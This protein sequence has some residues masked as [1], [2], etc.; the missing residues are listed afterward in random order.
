[1]VF[2]FRRLYQKGT[3]LLLA[4]SV[5]PLLAQ[6]RQAPVRSFPSLDPEGQALAFN[7]LAQ[8][9]NYTWK[10][11]ADIALWSSQAGERLGMGPDGPSAREL[12]LQAAQGLQAGFPENPKEGGARLLAYIHGQYL[13][14]YAPHQTL[15]D[16]LLVTGR[17]NCVSSAVFYAILAASAGL[18][19]QGVITRDH[20]FV[21]LH[22]GGEAVDVE[23]TNAYGYD[24]GNRR[25]FQNAFGKT[26]G[27]TYVPAR[28][29]RDRAAISALELVSLILSNRIA[30]A[31]SQRRYAGALTLAVNRDALLAGRREAVSSP[32]FRDPRA[33]LLDR[34]F[35]YTASLIQAGAEQDALAWMD[36]AQARY[37][38]DPRW[39]EAAHSAVNNLLVKLLRSQRYGEARTVLA[40][41]ARR[42]TEQA[43]RELEIQTVDAEFLFRAGKI[44]S[45]QGA[46]QLLGDLETALASGQLPKNRGEALRTFILLKEG[47]RAAESGGFAGGIR[48]L[49]GAIARYGANIRME[50][51]LRVYQANRIAELHNRFAGLFNQRDYAGAR[52]LILAALEEFPE[53]RRLQSDLQTLERTLGG[54]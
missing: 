1:M 49:E 44:T 51:A 33:D 16:T 27:F 36:I 54:R 39:E 17:Y 35:N 12:L 42:L 22:A 48:Y 10:D 21:S 31:E 23:T 5:S 50:E 43:R 20:A 4:V 53:N 25:E 41:N 46:E 47:E 40:Q 8:S 13:K 15:L 29:Y 32:F 6:S 14:S 28:N 30:E 38:E 19:V 34:I 11:L 7:R 3:L 9:G 45:P 18:E 2:P 37:P 24:P 52:R 26:T